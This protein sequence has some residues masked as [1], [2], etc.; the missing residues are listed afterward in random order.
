MKVLCIGHAAYDITML[1][2]SYP[3]ENTKNRV[4]QTLECG[5]GSASNA[6]YLLGKWGIDTTFLGIVGQDIY[7][8]RIAQELAEA[9]VNTKYLQ[10]LKQYETTLSMV[11]VNQENGSRTIISHHSD[12]IR[13]KKQILDFIPDIIL[14]DGQEY[15]CSMDLLKRYPKAISILDAGSATAEMVH[16]ARQVD[17]VVC[18]KEFAESVVGNPFDIN[19]IEELKLL[20]QT[21]CNQFRGVIIVTLEDEGCL[22]QENGIV[23][24]LPTLKVTALDTTGA[25]DIFHGAFTY[26]ISQNMP[27]S[28]ILLISNVAGALSVTKI[29]TRNSIPSLQEVWEACRAFK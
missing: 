13:L 26:G 18:S 21:L 8:Y 22:Y 23:K 6:A 15:E 17:Y 12:N 24:L 10:F 2:N 25:G 3:V 19:N 16:L 9:S 5:G 7:G 28:Q 14:M 29:G 1:V 4:A 20:Y 27:L 11:I